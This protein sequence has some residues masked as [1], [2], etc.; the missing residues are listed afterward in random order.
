MN[1]SLRFTVPLACW[2]LCSPTIGICRASWPHNH[3]GQHTFCNQNLVTN[4]VDTEF[5]NCYNKICMNSSV[6]KVNVACWTIRVRL[7]AVA[8]NL[9]SVLAAMSDSEN[10]QSPMQSVTGACLPMMKRPQREPDHSPASSAKF[11]NAWSVIFH[12]P[13]IQASAPPGASAQ[14]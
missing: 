1:P 10:T 7:P 12:S 11:T 3:S 13:H 8:E 6:N 14:V 4:I 9:P 5:Q 2:A